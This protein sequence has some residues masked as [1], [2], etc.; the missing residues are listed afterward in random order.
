MGAKR[1]SS[2][3]SW[4]LRRPASPSTE[5][6]FIILSMSRS[7]SSLPVGMSNCSA[8]MSRMYLGE[9]H[10]LGVFWAGVGLLTSVSDSLFGKFTSLASKSMF[11]FKFVSPAAIF[12]AAVSA[13]FGEV[14]NGE[15]EAG[16]TLKSSSL[17]QEN[18]DTSDS[19][20]FSRFQRLWPRF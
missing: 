3:N 10:W 6:W 20:E 7:N 5:P 14:Q 18:H 1:D 2:Q 4:S 19:D 15:L 11:E 9:S 16:D 17:R 12:L 13:K 8:D